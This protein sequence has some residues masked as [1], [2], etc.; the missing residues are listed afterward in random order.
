M[1]G[2]THLHM[3]KILLTELATML[4]VKKVDTARLWCIERGIPIFGRNQ[5]R[6]VLARDVEIEQ[7][8]DLIAYLIDRYGKEH[9][10]KVYSMYKDNDV[11]GLIELKFASKIDR[12]RPRH[13]DY[14]PKTDISAGFLNEI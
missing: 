2:I 10:Y 7:D 14:K 9:W 11:E 6:W 5:R 12:I 4:K 8:L 1:A 3:D 13:S